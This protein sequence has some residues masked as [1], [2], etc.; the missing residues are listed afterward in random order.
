[1]LT[2]NGTYPW[3]L[4]TQ[5]FRSGKPSHSGGRKTDSSVWFVSNVK[6]NDILGI[7]WG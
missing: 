2:T 3:S 4:V 6:F 7:F 1:V 5:I